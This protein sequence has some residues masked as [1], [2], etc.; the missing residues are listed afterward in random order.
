MKR[1][2]E[3]GGG[4]KIEMERKIE[5]RGREKER[6]RK[7]GGEEKIRKTM[8]ESEG[9]MERLRERACEAGAVVK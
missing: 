3:G 4:A 9:W 7:R 8:R 1:E 2:R 6:K 5:G